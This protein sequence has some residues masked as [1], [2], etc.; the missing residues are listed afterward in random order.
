MIFVNNEVKEEILKIKEELF[1]L[2]NLFIDIIK[3]GDSR[4]ID[5]LL[6]NCLDEY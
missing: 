6:N 4:E 5:N 2:N 3:D 1:K